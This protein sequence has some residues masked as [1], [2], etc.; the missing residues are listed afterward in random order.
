MMLVNDET[1]R[2]IAIKRLKEKNDFRIHLLVYL[3]V[4]AMLVAVWALTGGF[5]WP[6]FPIAGWGIGVLAHGYSVFYGNIYSEDQ[7]QREM[8]KLPR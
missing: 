4:N 2:D 8:S 5:F 7:I 1:R 3:G 6:L